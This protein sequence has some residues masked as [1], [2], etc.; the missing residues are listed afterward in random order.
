[1]SVRVNYE[2]PIGKIV[3]RR[4]GIRPPLDPAA[5]GKADKIAWKKA[6]GNPG[7]PKGV[8]RFSTHEEA[9]TWKLKMLTRPRPS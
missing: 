2:E 8:Y 6:F 7:I 1:M 4:T 9:E 5:N 3:G